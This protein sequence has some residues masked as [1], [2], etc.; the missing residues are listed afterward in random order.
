[1]IY[2]L[3]RNR[4]A[5]FAKWRQVFAAHAEAHRAAGLILVNFMQGIEDP[6]NVFFIFEVRDTER[7]RAFINA[8]GSAQAAKA[9]GVLDAEY[10]FVQSSKGYK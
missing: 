7:A 2:M 5:D 3:C 10:H 1:M 4:V 8:P 9:S 6:N